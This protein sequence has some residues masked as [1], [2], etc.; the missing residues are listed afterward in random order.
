M[1][2][3]TGGHPEHIKLTVASGLDPQVHQAEQQCKCKGARTGDQTG[4]NHPAHYHQRSY[5]TH[6]QP[7]TAVT[8][9]GSWAGLMA[10]VEYP[11]T[12]RGRDVACRS[13]RTRHPC[14]R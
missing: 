10:T 13:C 5:L 9:S 12:A 8:L 6:A 7:D 14:A 3:G 11:S 2:I 1:T 4:S